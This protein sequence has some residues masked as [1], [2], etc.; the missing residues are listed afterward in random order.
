MFF[1]KIDK[2]GDSVKISKQNFYIIHENQN[3]H[4]NWT[5]L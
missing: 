1:I 2:K 4:A 5:Q 3:I